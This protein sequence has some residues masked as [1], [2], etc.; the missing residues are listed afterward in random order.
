[1][2]RSRFTYNQ[3]T[4]ANEQDYVDLGLSCA[5]IC[6]ALDRGMDGKTLDDLSQPVH[7]AISQLMT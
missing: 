2:R 5:D 3:D 4:I 1:M 7:D 6:K